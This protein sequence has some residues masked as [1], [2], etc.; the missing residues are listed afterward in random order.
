M[1]QTYVGVHNA[2]IV[3]VRMKV[4]MWKWTTINGIS[5]GKFTVEAQM[6]TFRYNKSKIIIDTPA[7]HS[8]LRSP[9]KHS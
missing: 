6:D 8:W 1:Q 3:N 4:R 9:C 5:C 7:E 2:Y